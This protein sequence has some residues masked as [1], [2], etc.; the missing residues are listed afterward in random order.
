[1]SQIVDKKGKG[2]MVTWGVDLERDPLE[3]EIEK[4]RQQNQEQVMEKISNTPI[5]NI[6]ISLKHLIK[7]GESIRTRQLKKNEQLKTNND[8]HQEIKMDVN[9]RP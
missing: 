9:L 5:P 7:M 4:L 6:T 2:K 1:M 8:P 3:T